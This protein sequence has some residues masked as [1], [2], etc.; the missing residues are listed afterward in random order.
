MFLPPLV[1]TILSSLIGGILSKSVEL[2]FEL[3]DNA[4]ECFFEEIDQSI[5]ASLE[6]QV[7]SVQSLR[8]FKFTKLFVT[9]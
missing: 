9:I 4:V 7:I 8:L 5:S 3:P 6:Y 1:I 2:T